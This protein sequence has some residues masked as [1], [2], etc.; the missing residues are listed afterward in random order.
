MP[1][2]AA[3]RKRAP[4]YSRGPHMCGPYKPVDRQAANSAEVGVPDDP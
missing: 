3:A 1:G 4:P 2:P